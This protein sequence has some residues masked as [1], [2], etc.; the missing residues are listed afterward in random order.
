L[1]GGAVATAQT[2]DRPNILFVL[3]DDHR[4]VP[5]LIDPMSAS[6]YTGTAIREEHGS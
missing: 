6:S 3:S 1:A 2:T 5:S 4:L